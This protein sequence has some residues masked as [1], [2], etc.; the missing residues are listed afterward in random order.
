MSYAWCVSLRIAAEN[1]GGQE[2]K[3]IWLG[4]LSWP[5]PV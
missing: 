3:G 1:I 5:L 2:M 4:M